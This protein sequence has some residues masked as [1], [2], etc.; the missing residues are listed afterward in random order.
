MKRVHLKR[1]VLTAAIGL[2]LS[3]SGHAGGP[4]WEYSAQSPVC[5]TVSAGST[6]TVQYTVT[7][8]SRRSKNLELRETAGLSA[9]PCYLATKG[10]ECTLTVTI[11]G[12]AVPAGGIQEGPIL[13]EQ[14]NPSQ[15]YHPSKN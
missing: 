3:T 15:C 7:N 11:N 12:S 13:C 1:A 9:S 5:V 10:S 2:L 8:V 6:E 14:D 4:L